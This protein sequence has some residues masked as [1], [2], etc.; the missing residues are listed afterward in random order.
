MAIALT[1][2]N[3]CAENKP[4]FEEYQLQKWLPL[5]RSR[6][7]AFREKGVET[8]DLVQEGLIGLLYAIRA[9]D[10]ERNASFETFA[11]VCITNR[12]RSA[13]SY[14]GKNPN[15]VSLDEDEASALSQSDPQ[16][17]II[18]REYAANWLKCADEL[19]SKLE[20]QALRLYLAGYSYQQM[21]QKL[22]CSTK[23]VDNALCRA[24]SKLHQIKF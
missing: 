5:V 24:K 15:T 10:S 1:E 7:N 22:K 9:F 21:A 12:L 19:L 2:K 17:Y 11:Y 18:G 16:D 6:A 20:G 23:A 4:D 14:A 13:V 3:L 8:D